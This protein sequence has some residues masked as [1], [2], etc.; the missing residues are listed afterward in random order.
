MSEGNSNA[1][2]K[3]SQLDR[4]KNKDRVIIFFAYKQSPKVGLNPQLLCQELP[5]NVL[6]H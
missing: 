1:G 5:I 2:E 3:G 4:V 6:V